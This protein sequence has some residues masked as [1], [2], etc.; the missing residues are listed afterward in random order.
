VQ[1]PERRTR[2]DLIVAA[3]LAVTVAVAAIV[4]W[5]RSDARGTTSITWDGAATAP[6]A[7]QSV[8]D[9]LAEIWRA[10][11]G[12]TDR[13]AVLDAT[14]VTADG[15]TVVGRD[16]TTGT[17][18]WSYTRNRPLCA[19]TSHR[20]IVVAVY[21]DPRGCGQ[22]TA[23]RG[24]SGERYTARSSDTD[25]AIRLV[26]AGSHLIA[27]GGTRLEMWRSDLVRTVEYGR[28]DAPVTPGAQPRSG[29]ELRSAAAGSE[30][31]AVLEL[32]P[33]EAAQRLTLL[34]PTPDDAQK[35]EQYASSVLPDAPA[36]ST[37]RIVAVSG[38]RAAVF[39]PGHDGTTPRIEVFDR[40]GKIV[41]GHDL[42]AGTP[43]GGADTVAVPAQDLGG[44]LV[45]WTGSATVGLDSGDLAPKW[46]VPGATG[47]SAA[48]A[49][50]LLVPVERG[51]AVVDPVTGEVTRTIPLPPDSGGSADSP[52]SDAVA[53][54]VLGD[55]VLEQRGGNVVAYR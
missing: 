27:L 46:T 51:L 20:G 35:P 16:P 49:G 17:Q 9:T 41:A 38:E 36:G 10:P 37:A 7:A 50:K 43:V 44:R 47:R 52:D 42:P 32:C 33:G 29:C 8:P 1:T 45:W 18:R 28:V 31:L 24:D 23:L 12:A 26:D 11:S 54:A 14:V 15:D 53:V 6:A 30:L 21:E 5:V 3:A 34:A 40:N 25:D 4:V 48:M 55:I 22:T 39:V 2:T 19:A 13:P